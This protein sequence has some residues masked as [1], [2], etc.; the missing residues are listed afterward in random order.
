MSDRPGPSVPRRAD[1]LPDGTTIRE[2]GELGLLADILRIIPPAAA[3]E[4][5]PGDDAAVLQAPDGRVVVTTDT[6]IEG[7][8]FRLDWSTPEDVGGKAVV[9]NLADVAAMGARPTGLVIALAL[10]A[11]QTVGWVR[12]FARGVRDA[13]ERLAPGCG[14]IGGDLATS[15]T[16]TVA[17]TALGDLEGG[18]AVRRDGA[19]PGDVV[20]LAG[21]AGRSAAGLALLLA[22]D[23]DA[24]A[25]AAA[26]ADADAAARS[27]RAA[28]ERFAPALIN[29][30]LRPVAPVHAGPAARTAGA[31]AMMDVSDGL[32]L[33]AWRLAT[34]SGVVVDLDPDSDALASER[35]IIADTLERVPAAALEVRAGT[36]GEPGQVN[37]NPDPDAGPEAA[38][39]VAALWRDRPE[40]HPEEFV[41][42][43]GEE[44]ALLATFPA[45]VPLPH[46]F[47]SI[48]RV[49]APALAV[50]A[51][52]VT[53]AGVPRRPVGWDPYRAAD[54]TDSATSSE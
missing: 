53:V 30:H 33:D 18:A 36:I 21:T 13:L 4:I 2:A 52:T 51:G 29:Q 40:F 42:R 28:L 31:T 46:P 5:G 19:R 8:D 20:A 3:A 10:P 48:G 7:P 12:G 49:V 17:V 26:D 44:H 38:P 16:L 43:G 14:V 39:S 37:P 47:H 41:L 45:K 54:G 25:D 27:P 22:A 15:T 9:S 24:D 32:L 11:E 6:M 34:A 50:P 35:A 1:D 23:A